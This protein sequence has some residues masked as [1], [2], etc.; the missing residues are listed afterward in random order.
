M[1]FAAILLKTPKLCEDGIYWNR[2]L[3]TGCS[4]CL[5]TD[6][7]WRLLLVPP[8]PLPAPRSSVSLTVRATAFTVV[9]PFLGA[10][11]CL[12][13]K[14]SYSFCAS[15]PTANN[16]KKSHMRAILV[17]SPFSS[18]GLTKEEGRHQLPMLLVVHRAHCGPWSFT[19]NRAMS[20]F[21]WLKSQTS[22]SSLRSQKT[23]PC[24]RDWQG[25]QEL[26]EKWAYLTKGWKWEICLFPFHGAVY[27]HI[28]KVP[29]PSY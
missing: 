1:L 26:E 20:P 15:L 3:Q 10:G 8:T 27:I 25:R 6:A 22:P 21:I 17:H 9:W 19:H 11:L 23:A 14:T 28:L 24:H 18:N 4:P 5:L 2:M 12:K 7:E 29:V 16:A 13:K